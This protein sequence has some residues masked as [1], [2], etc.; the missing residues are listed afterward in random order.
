[1][2][3]KVSVLGLALLPFGLVACTS[4]PGT[5]F[6]LFPQGHKITDTAKGLRDANGHP[7]QVPRELEKIPQPPYVVEPGDVL[8]VQS[9]DLDSPIR[10]PGDQPV[11]PDGTINL[12]KYG[13]LPVMGK[14]VPEIEV[15]VRSTVRAQ[16]KDPGFITVRLVSRES[17]VYYVIGEVNSPGK[18]KL[19]G[20]E[21]VLDAIL[22][23]GGLNSRGS[24]ENI[25]LSRP[26]KPNCPRIVLPVCW[27]QIVQMGDTTTNYQ[28]TAGDR[29]YVPTRT[30]Q[31][32]VPCLNKRV[33]TPCK[34]GTHAPAVLPPYPGDSCVEPHNSFR[35]ITGVLTTEQEMLPMPAP[36]PVPPKK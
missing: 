7:L 36:Q 3:W 13:L 26:T 12:G 18:F 35:G 2:Y 20:N 8:L 15:M 5:G 17:K 28:V 23:A 21:T 10:L 16:E 4:T 33:K 29:I 32:M 34:C 31:E 27:T 14:T 1:M 24:R 9:A 22:Q 30:C 11:L 19:A 6:S 25:I